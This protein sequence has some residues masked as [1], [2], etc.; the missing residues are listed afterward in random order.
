MKIL[1]IMMVSHFVADFLLQSRE[2][3]KTKSTVFKVLCEHVIIQY[4]TLWAFLLFFVGPTLAVE[5]SLCNALVHGL[6]DWNIWKLYKWSAKYRIEKRIDTHLFL[7][8]DGAVVLADKWEYW[9]DHL[10]YTTIGIDQLLHGLTLVA[11]AGLF[12]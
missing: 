10:F 3:G 6:I 1:A 7:K 4:L 9:E 5:I 12:L 11:L 8:A 2:M